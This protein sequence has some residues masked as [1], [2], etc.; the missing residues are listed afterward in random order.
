MRTLPRPLFLLVAIP[1][2]QLAERIRSGTARARFEQKTGLR[3]VFR[4]RLDS[5]GTSVLRT[6]RAELSPPRTSP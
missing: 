5:S 6:A 3:R 2:D 1:V 4:A